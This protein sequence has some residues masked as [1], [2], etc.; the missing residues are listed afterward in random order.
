MSKV[1]LDALIPREDFEISGVQNSTNLFSSISITNFTG[2]FFY[3]F[4]RKPDFQRETNEWES[5]KIIEFIES[6]INGELIP[7]IILWRS[8]TGLYFVIDGAHR[9]SALISWINDDYGDGEISKK[10]YNSIIN[11]E[12][13]D[14]ANK[15][16]QLVNKRIGKYLDI[17]KAPNNINSNPIFVE[18]AK[19]L[20][21]YSIQVQ[22][23][24]G[25]AKKAENSFF[26]INQQA[27]KIDPTE[28]KILQSRK[29]PNCI[30]A[31][32]IIRGGQ[33]H[34]YWAD[35]S[36]ENQAEIQKLSKEIHD[37][38][39]SPVL[40][41]PVKTLDIPIGGKLFSAQS[42]PLILE[43]V[44]MSNKIDDDFSKTLNDDKEGDVT[45][46]Y[47]K[48]ARKIAWRINSVHPSSLGLHPIVYFYSIEGKHKPA[49]FY[50]IV[51][52]L[53][54][55]ERKSYF[56]NFIK[57]R[58][59]FEKF[60]LD[61]DY[62]ITQIT[63]NFRSATRSIPH[64]V[65]FFLILISDLNNNI[66]LNESIQKIVKTEKFKFLKLEDNENESNEYKDFTTDTK[67]EVF[68]REAIKNGLRCKICNGFLHKNAISIDHIQRKEDGGL[69]IPDNGQLT[70]P[71]CNT[72]YKN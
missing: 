4:L 37:I 15:T 68:I 62:I 53:L 34:K 45:I 23:V 21:A 56:N 32:G 1:N 67:S 40:K 2:G 38:I 54:E 18:R 19:N 28:L 25:D 5:K 51:A 31:R 43:F 6:Y 55:L 52:F 7:A 27:S 10:F 48:Q 44:N 17:I 35:F 70:H 16:R 71:Y 59:Q 41:T 42:L 29:K 58:E 46:N 13:I 69:G 12:Q 63:R 49:S 33:G 50:Y 14:V 47:L 3:P 57:A 39:Y 11:E 8:Q 26:K 9:L 66:T 36:A 24:D 65:D 60:L 20:G 61:Y 72:T 30:A 22:W 64:V